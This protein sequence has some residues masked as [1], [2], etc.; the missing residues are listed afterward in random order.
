MTPRFLTVL[1]GLSKSKSHLKE[2]VTP[3]FNNLLPWQSFLTMLNFALLSTPGALLRKVPPLLRITFVCPL[4]SGFSFCSP[5]F[6]K[7]S[8][9]QS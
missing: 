6:R 1:N 2:K 9:Q 8:L 5:F 3:V 7:L 4:Q